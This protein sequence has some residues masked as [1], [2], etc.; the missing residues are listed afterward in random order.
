MRERNK[1]FIVASLRMSFNL[2]KNKISFS[3]FFSGFLH[4]INDIISF[5]KSISFNSLKS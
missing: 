3:A 4:T 2:F 1:S 5:L